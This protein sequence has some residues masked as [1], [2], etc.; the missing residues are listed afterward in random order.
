MQKLMIIDDQANY[1]QFLHDHLGNH[2]EIIVCSGCDISADLIARTKPDYMI[3]DLNSSLFEGFT[4]LRSAISLGA[5]P[6]VIGIAQMSYYF[7]ALVEREKNISSTISRPIN[8]ETIGHRLSLMMELPP[9]QLIPLPTRSQHLESMLLGLSIHVDW[10]GGK[11][12]IHV[13]PLAA[14]DPSLSY[15]KELYFDVGKR[16]GQ[17]PQNVERNIRTAID[18]GFSQGNMEVWASYFPPD[19]TGKVRKPSNTS[20]ISHLATVL[21]AQRG[22]YREDD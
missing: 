15:S 9:N 13:I 18:R 20:F 16:Y 17:T 8:Q 19:K 11:S 21:N 4:L 14:D 12:L 6:A 3:L 22:Q 5:N 10:F 7:N 1:V 2:C